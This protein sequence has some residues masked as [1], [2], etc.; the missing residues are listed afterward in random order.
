MSWR[1]EVQTDS[2]A[3]F[4]LSISDLM[5]AL[6]MIFILLL[7]VTLISLQDEFNAKGSIA[8]EYE[9]VKAEIIEDLLKEFEVDLERWGAELD[10]ATL[11]IRFTQQN[12]LFLPDSAILRPEFQAILSDFFP[13]YINTLYPKFQDSIEELRIEGHTAPIDAVPYFSHMQL[14]QA[15]TNSVLNYIITSIRLPSDDVAFMKQVIASSGFADSRPI[16]EDDQVNLSESRRVEFRIRTNSEE[17]IEDI[18]GVSRGSRAQ[19]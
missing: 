3:G 4:D 17:R 10:Q 6:L 7:V 15:R 12:I 11:S 5:S 13:R 19:Q 1:N 16:F 14:S 2:N 18:L 9:Q 8:E